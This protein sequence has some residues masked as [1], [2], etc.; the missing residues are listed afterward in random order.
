MNFS[1]SKYTALVQCD[2]TVWLGKHKPEAAVFDTGTLSRMAAGNDF[3]DLA[4]RLFGDFVETTAYDGEKLDLAAM[5]AAT[6]RYLAEGR[7]VICEAAFSHDGLYCAVDILKKTQGGYAIYEVKS[8]THPNRPQYAVDIAYQ[9]FV[10]EKCGVPVTGTFV[11]TPN[12]DYELRG[13]LDITAL[14]KITDIS[15]SVEKELALVADNLKRAES[16]LSEPDEPKRA[17]SPRCFTPYTCAYWK[18]CSAH[19]PTP[20]VLD[21]YRLGTEEKFTLL[22]K[23]IVTMRDAY[24]SGVAADNKIR[25][26]QVEHQV[27]QRGT[28]CDKTQLRAFLDTLWYPLYF[29]DFETYRPLVPQY[30]GDSPNTQIP[31]QYSLHYIEREGGEVGHTEFLGEPTADPR[32]AIAKSLAERIPTDACVL[33]YNMS[34]EKGVLTDLAKR[35]AHFSDTL[36]AIAENARDLIVPFRSGACYN[37]AM[38][39]SFSIKSV[40]PALF[41]GDSELDYTALDG[42][43]NGEDAMTV[44]AMTA[45]MPSKEREQARRALLDYCRLDTLA[46]VKI[47]QRLRKLSE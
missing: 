29:L 35:Y 19:L 36:T 39:G 41:P 28:V 43:H 9:R 5:I 15:E 7:E 17:L 34:F 30:E 26:M 37:R 45:L 21:L 33:A 44:F 38:G 47:W 24:D 1:K 12:P 40:L 8:S 2:K 6:N 16:V 42:V 22:N 13:E 18:Y 25:R 27:F 46:M 31:F 32:E 20:S 4:M 11:V 10:L 14:C 23:G 3:G